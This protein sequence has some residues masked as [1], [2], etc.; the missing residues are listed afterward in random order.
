M[1]S[2]LQE[3]IA[4]ITERKGESNFL[5]FPQTIVIFLSVR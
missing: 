4:A 1:L 5:A 3:N 2:L